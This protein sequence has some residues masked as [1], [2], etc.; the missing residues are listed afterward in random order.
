MTDQFWAIKNNSTDD[1]IVAFI[2]KIKTEYF[3]DAQIA[4]KLARTLAESGDVISARSDFSVDVAS[5]GGP[6]SLSTL[7]CPLF[8]LAAGATVPKLGVPGRPAGG[9]DCLIQIEGYKSS[10]S[11]EEVCEILDATRYIHFMAGGRLAS[12]D[13]RVFRL[14]Q[15]C[16]GQEVPTLVAASLLS[17]KLAVGVQYAGLD[18]RVAS[19]GNFGRTWEEAREN[20]KLFI[21]AAQLLSIS[22]FPVMTDGRYPYQP[23]IG[24]SEA[25]LALSHLFNATDP[26]WLNEH[27]VQCRDLALACVP[28]TRRKPVLDATRVNLR[29]LFETN[30]IAQGTTYQR[31]ERLVE[32]TSAQHKYVLCAEE[33]GFIQFSLDGI[34]QSLMKWQK[35]AE[36]PNVEFPD[37]VGVILMRRPGEW[38]N[39]GDVLATIRICNDRVDDVLD[40]LRRS[41]C[42][43]SRL[44]LSPSIEG[45]SGNE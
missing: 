1:E 22:A 28:H 21:E 16:G 41:I 31:F 12:L 30:L 35:L 17:K 24:R 4:A 45:V 38:A 36:R 43:P 34:R 25:L 3:A 23:F 9:I 18:I 8:L 5:S 44:P 2:N 29:T 19:H 33:D 15:Q 10:F 6:S 14:R 7:L 40:D 37:P 13:G 11:A 42:K 20:A 32:L 26:A 27:Y 39:K